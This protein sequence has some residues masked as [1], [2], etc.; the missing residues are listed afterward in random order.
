M[1]A[2]WLVANPQLHRKDLVG[3]LISVPASW[4]GAVLRGQASCRGSIQLHNGTI[5]QCQLLHR[6]S[7]TFQFYAARR[8]ISP[9]SSTPPTPPVASRATACAPSRCPSQSH[10]RLLSS[11]NRFTLTL[12]YASQLWNLVT[13]GFF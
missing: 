6:S 1:R 10:H 3:R 11:V 9:S 4:K 2:V 8:R 5:Q 7:Y 13:P 12:S